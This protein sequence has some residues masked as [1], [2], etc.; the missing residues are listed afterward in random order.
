VRTARNAVVV[1][2]VVDLLA[3]FAFSVRT[4]TT[5]A[6]TVTPVAL[7]PAPAATAAAPAS[8][9]LVLGPPVSAVAAPVP[10]VASTP[11]TTQIVPSSPSTTAPSESPA[12]SIAA[13]TCPIPLEPPA[14]SGGLQS[15]IDFAP[16][17]GEFSAEAFAAASAYQPALQLLGPILAQYPSIAP[18]IEPLIGPLLTQW[19]GLLD[20]VFQLI[21]PYYAPHRTQVLE[22]EAKL[23]DALA[24]YAQKLIASPLGAC[25]VDLEAALVNDTRNNDK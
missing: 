9:P 6:R 14:K 10:A 21:A 23:A 7:A 18:K 24:P 3:L 22:A 20:T 2:V 5:T 1:L 12:P 25:V 16:A 13:A 4:S 11:T 19:E 17:F 15:L 8:A